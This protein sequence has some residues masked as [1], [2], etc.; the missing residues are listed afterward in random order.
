VKRK[1]LIVAIDGPAG[2]GKSTVAKAVAAALNYRYIDTGAMYR[3]VTLKCMQA[4]VNLADQEAV[5]DAA[6]QVRLEF[7][8]GRAGMILLDGQDVS[9]AIRTPEVSRNVSAAVASYPGVR[10]AMVEQ[11]QA[12]G[13]EGG[14]VMEGRDITTVVFPDAEIK[15]F[16]DASQETRARRRYEELKAKGQEQPYAELLADLKRRD[17]EDLNRPGGALKRAPGARV[18]DSSGQSVADVVSAI[19]ALVRKREHYPR[20]RWISGTTIWVV[21]TLARLRLD[22]KIHHDEWLPPAGPFILARNHASHLDP[23]LVAVS[24][25]REVHFM[26]R[27]TLF[28]GILGWGIRLVNAHPIIRGQ[29]P[30][31]DW[32]SF[33]RIPKSGGVLL[34]FPEGTRT[35]TGDLQRGKSGF[36]KL[37]H[38]CQVPVYPAYVKGSYKAWPKG[39]KPQKHPVSVWFGPAVPLAD[40]LA[41]PDDKRILREISDRVMAA[42]ANVKEEAEKQ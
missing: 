5:E 35:E 15:V 34:V 25:P 22:L 17:Q 11:Q 9:E 7:V 33:T 36:G 14:I 19:L 18:V 23:P 28:K 8:A 16:L 38:M 2:A 4:G 39:G 1:Q 20:M 26:A 29:G 13:R 24:T 6:R 27:S 31:Q 41:Q 32:D 30:N 21:K 37:V 12:M 42:I 10:R 3:A 40:L